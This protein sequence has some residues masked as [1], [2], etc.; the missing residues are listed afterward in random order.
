MKKALIV[1]TISGFVPQFE[2]PN[3]YT[4]QSMGYEI[5]YASNFHTPIYGYDN[6]RLDNTGII[7][8]QIDFVKSPYQ[9]IK[10]I[11]AYKQ[12][13]RLIRE[14]QIDLIH[15]HT[16]VGGVLGRLAGRVCEVKVI[17]T[18]HGFHFYTGGP[19]LNW[20]IYY[21][22]EKFLSRYTEVLITINQ[23]DFLRAKK[24]HSCRVTQINGVGLHT[25]QYQRCNIDRAQK[26]YEL[27]IDSEQFILCSVGEINRN[28]NHEVVMKALYELKNKDILYLICGDGPYKEHLK[29]LAEQL[30][31][32]NQVLF[33]GYR[34]DVKEILSISDCFA[35]PSRREG[36][37]MA[38]LEAMAAG[39]PLLVA[40]SRGTREYAEDGK[41]GFVY[42]YND[43][44]GFAEGL[45][46]MIEDPNLRKT[47][48][49]YNQKCIAKFD[50]NN[51][52]SK[53][54]KVYKSI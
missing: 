24:F 3:V 52:T 37:G 1:T 45:K 28:K 39:L 13:L 12:L 17:Y 41:T 23:E 27:G 42:Q 51:V 50:I 18:A 54:E 47:M 19:L 29:K 11:K 40:A 15:C 46:K 8:H 43:Y 25:E 33:L 16:P 38:A 2:M 21:P 36:L 31:I 4:L 32:K 53:M 49:K 22:I 48:G 10:I 34:S 44:K 14:E 5:H 35:F 20:L 30:D 26:C 7:C 9:L 6:K